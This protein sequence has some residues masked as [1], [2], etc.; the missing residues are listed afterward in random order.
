MLTLL[1]HKIASMILAHACF[2]SYCDAQGYLMK[3]FVD[4]LKAALK[5]SLEPYFDD[6]VYADEER[7]L[8]RR[9]VDGLRKRTAQIL[10]P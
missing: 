1:T 10:A 4:E 5:S 3:R 6:Q 2:I 8:A 9:A 7:L